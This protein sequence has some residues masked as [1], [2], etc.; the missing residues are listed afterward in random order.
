M[1]I[2]LAHFRSGETDGVSLEM[3]KWKD[4]LIQMG[5]DVIFLAGSEGLTNAYL[6]PELHYKH[7]RNAKFVY[8]AYDKLLDYESEQ[9]F[10]D[11]VLGFTELI[12][13][14]LLDFVESEQIEMLIPFNIW[15]LGWSLP[16]G[17][18]FGN[19]VRKTG[20]PCL[21]FHHNFYWERELY[22][23]P[24]CPI[25][26]DWLQTYFP[27]ELPSVRHAVTNQLSHDGLLERRN[28]NSYVIPNVFDFG[29]PRWSSDAY[30]QGLRE[31][32]G[33]RE[34]DIVI[35]QATRVTERKTIELGIDVV[36]ALEE[37]LNLIKEQGVTLYNGKPLSE[38]SRLV[39]LLAGMPE[40][41]Y[42]YTEQLRQRAEQLQVDL[43]FVNQVIGYSRTHTGGHNIYSLW[44]AYVIADFITY[45]SILESWGNQLLEA[46]FAN[47]PMII[48]EYPVYENDIRQYGFQFV[49]LGNRYE[50][51]PDGLAQ[52]DEAIVKAAAREMMALLT[53]PAQYEQI[54]NNNFNTASKH[55]SYESLHALLVP[56]FEEVRSC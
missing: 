9:D 15:S 22:G 46:V 39:Y 56:I 10:A 12:E 30:N 27:P 32:V 49:S 2:A 50:T 28:L 36:A 47:K 55:F 52:V 51:S 20:I 13:K 33:I 5:H 53:D 24:T 37:E 38:N 19:A 7:P 44:D 25:V 31:A 35:L 11:D 16:A 8:N 48:F 18:A 54:V 29:Q 42:E 41:T 3:D 45:P 40:S 6:I 14:K 26:K 23:K 17:I 43:R 34:E 1:K 4:V 21:G